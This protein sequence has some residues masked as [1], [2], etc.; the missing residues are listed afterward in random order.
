MVL[1]DFLIHS[2]VLNIQLSRNL[3]TQTRGDRFHE[4]INKWKL[5]LIRHEKYFPVLPALTTADNSPS[6]ERA[7]S[8]ECVAYD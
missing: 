2:N 6:V 1:N 3:F 7:D 5:D 4:R 8:K